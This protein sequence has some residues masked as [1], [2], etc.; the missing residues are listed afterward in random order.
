MELKKTLLGIAFAAAALAPV[1]ARADHDDDDRSRAVEVHVHDGR[2]HHGATP[3]GVPSQ[4][5]RYELRTVQRWVPGRYQQVWV[6]QQCRQKRRRV[7]CRGGYYEQRW[8]P[9]HYVTAQEWVWVPA[10]T[11]PWPQPSYYGAPAGFSASANVAVAPV[12]LTFTASF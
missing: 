1:A 10:A 4:T 6:P 8:E 12:D 3:P 5:G 7:K 11:R 9:A 2:C